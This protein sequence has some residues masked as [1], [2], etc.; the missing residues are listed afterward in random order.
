MR[1]M[2]EAWKPNMAEEFNPSWINVLGESILEWFNGY[3][4]SFMCVGRKSHTLDNKRH[5][6]CCGLTY[7]LW[8]YQIAEGKDRPQHLGQK[9]YNELKK[10]ASLMLSI[11]RPIFVSSKAVV[12]NG[13]FCVVKGIT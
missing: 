5:T 6:I 11:C 10:M 13:G 7:I 12:L 9:E 4:L 2:E 8:I 1:Q 3:A